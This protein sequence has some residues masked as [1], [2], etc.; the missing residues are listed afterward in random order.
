MSADPSHVVPVWRRD[1]PILVGRTVT[2]R[3]PAFP[4]AGT[5]HDLLSLADATPFGLDLPVSELAV[6]DLVGRAAR[7]RAAGRSFT[8]AVTLTAS[9]AIVGLVQV[10]QLDPAFEA[11]EWECTIA[12][13]ARGTGVFLEAARLV[14]SFAFARSAR[15]ASKRA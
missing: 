10:R 1:L 6:Q 13:S 2:L 14:G 3:E 12:P 7:D 11:A 4:D 5:L 8:Y 15:I 9:R